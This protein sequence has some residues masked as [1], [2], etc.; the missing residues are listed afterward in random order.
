MATGD[1][2]DIFRRLKR[3]LVQWFGKNTITNSAQTSATPN[4]DA[5]LFGL[6]KTESYIYSLITDLNLQTRIR[7][8]T[9]NNLD[10]ISKDYLGTTLP[11]RAGESDTSFRNRILA[12][13]VQER[14]TK[15][16]MIA[17]LTKLTGIAPT[18][19]EGFDTGDTYAFD[20]NFYFDQNTG[21]Y[22]WSKPYTAII[23]A[24][25]P[26]PILT[27][28]FGGYDISDLDAS[29]WGGFGYDFEWNNAYYDPSQETI[30]ISASDIIYAVENTKC[31][32]TR[33][34]LTI[35]PGGQQ[36]DT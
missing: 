10:Y 3:N 19:I 14:A 16:A 31:Y 26:A 4:L 22:G 35:F 32:G 6:A 36:Y 5:L 23:Y 24:T 25:I 20:Q 34:Y 7:T 33:M 15:A 21:G 27:P 2:L 8:A 13:L 17:I 9:G 1:Q 30:I 28:F 11:R 12:N 29:F 18:V